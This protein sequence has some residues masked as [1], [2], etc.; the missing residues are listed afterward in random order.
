MPLKEV[1]GGRGGPSGSQ[2]VRAVV[3][4][5]TKRMSRKA[6]KALTLGKSKPVSIHR[7]QT[8][9]LELAKLEVL[10]WVQA[11]SA[12]GALC[13]SR[14][15]FQRSIDVLRAWL[16][17]YDL[18]VWSI[19]R[20]WETCMASVKELEEVLAAEESTDDEAEMMKEKERYDTK[21]VVTLRREAVEEED[22]DGGEGDGESESDEEDDKPVRGPG[23]SAK[24]QGKRPVK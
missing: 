21:R 7:H 1:V 12:I 18:E 22:K 6:R 15:A 14:E 8:Y 19:L 23:L 20:E 16:D 2:Q 10:K 11:A 17:M 24:A 3:G 13:T 9:I 5:Q 4:S